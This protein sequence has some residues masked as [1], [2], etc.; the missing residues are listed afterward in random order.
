MRLIRV[1]EFETFTNPII[2]ASRA[3]LLEEVIY[4]FATLVPVD[5]ESALGHIGATE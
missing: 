2:L 1:S 5:I 3:M 4:C